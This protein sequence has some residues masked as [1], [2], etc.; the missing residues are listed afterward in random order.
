MAN[1]IFKVLI[2]GAGGHGQVVADILLVHQRLGEIKPIGFIDDDYNLTNTYAMGLPILGPLNTI[3]NIE[4]DFVVTAI[5]NNRVRR[6]ICQRWNEMGVSFYRAV[7]PWSSVAESVKLGV[8]VMICAGV[9]IN[10]STRI[11]EHSIINT[12]SS[13]DHHCEIGAYVHIAPGARL[14]GNVNIG[15]GTLVGMGALI[16]PGIIVGED[17]VIGAGSVV[18]KDLPDGSE[19][20]GMPARPI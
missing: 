9:I 3:E 1:N 19:V 17:C 8:G 5:G 13:V 11:C 7:H 2:A 10:P 18:T 14:G 15:S 4:L 16:L 20:I 12:G 6:E